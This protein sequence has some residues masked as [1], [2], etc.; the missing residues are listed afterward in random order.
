MVAVKNV[1]ISATCV[2]SALA[3]P[4]EAT[5]R[6][7][8][9]WNGNGGGNN[10][11]SQWGQQ[12]QGQA[13][14]QGQSQGQGQAQGQAQGGQDASASSGS[15]GN[16][17]TAAAGTSSLAATSGE[18]IST[19]TSGMS[20]DW[21]YQNWMD[22]SGTTMTLGDGQYSVEWTEAAGNVVSG[23]GWNPASAK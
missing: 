10:G 4:M 6:Q 5:K 21:Y 20:G 8:G 16:S 1:L 17:S 23:I 15:S 7:W 2:A 18:T 9:G 22:G 19:S 14:G 3:A 13:Q 12:G 11:M